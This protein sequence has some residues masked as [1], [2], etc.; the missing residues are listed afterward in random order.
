MNA[1]LLTAVGLLALGGCAALFPAD[2]LDPRGDWRS[3]D[4]QETFLNVDLTVA[5]SRT[6]SPYEQCYRE[7]PLV[8]SDSAG[9]WAFD[10]P[11]GGTL[12]V[13]VD[14]DGHLVAT[15]EIAGQTTTRTFRRVNAAPRGCDSGTLPGLQRGSGLPHEE[16]TWKTFEPDRDQ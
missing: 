6:W 7:T 14:G 1:P 4:G 2:L 3:L 16:R 11:D 12:T 8:R 9:A 15:R 5:E 13:R 10:A